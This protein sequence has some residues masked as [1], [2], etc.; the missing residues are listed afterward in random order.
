MGKLLDM[1]CTECESVLSHVS[2]NDNFF[3]RCYKC[4]YCLCSDC[5][6]YFE[7]P[8]D[9]YCYAA[10]CK[11]CLHNVFHMKLNEDVIGKYSEL[12][13]D[14]YF[15]LFDKKMNYVLPHKLS[16]SAYNNM[17]DRQLYVDELRFD[18]K[19]LLYIDDNVSARIHYDNTH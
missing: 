17:F 13:K 18:K 15:Y 16:E 4:N 2:M 7:Y 11:R 3:H 19:Y 9:M 8:E 5:S 6:K 1:K 14:N 12:S 10:M